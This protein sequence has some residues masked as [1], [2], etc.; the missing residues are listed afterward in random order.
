MSAAPTEVAVH[1]EGARSGWGSSPT[2]RVHRLQGVRGRLQAVERPPGR[3][4]RRRRRDAALRLHG[5]L[6]PSSWRHVRFVE[7][8]PPTAEERELRRRRSARERAARMPRTYRRRRGSGGPAA[9]PATRRWSSLVE[10]PRRRHRDARRRG[11]RAGDRRA[12][13]ALGELDRWAF[14]SD[15]CKHCTN[16]GCLDACPTGA[17]IRTEFQTVI[18]Q[19]DICNGC[20]YC[21]PSC[22]FGVIDRDPYDGRAREVHALLRPPQDGLEPACAKACP[23]DAIQFGPRD[24]LVEQA[25]APRARAARARARRRYLYGAGD[26]PGEQLAGDLGAFFLLTEPP[27]RF[28]LPAQA[29][30]PA[31]EN[32]PTATAAGLAAGTVAAAGRGGELRGHPPP[33]APVSHRTGRRPRRSSAAA[34]ARASSRRGA[35]S[36]PAVGTRGSPPAG[37]G[38]SRA[39]RGVARPAWGDARWSYLYGREGAAR[40]GSD[41]PADG[42]VA[43]AARRMRG[44]R[45]VPVPALGPFI[46]PPVWTWEVPVYFWFGGMATG[47]SFA[48]LPRDVAGD[49]RAA[50]LARK[51]LAG[52][53]AAVRAAARCS[54]SGGRCASCTCCGSSSRARR[55]RWARG[56]STAFSNGSVAPWPP[57]SSGAR[58]LA[59]AAGAATGVIGTYLGSYTGVLLAATAVPVWARSRAF[60]PA[61]FICTAAATG[62]A[63]NRLALAATG[64]P[65][66]RPDAPGARRRS[67]RSPWAASSSCR[68]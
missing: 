9:A 48:A 50:A 40:Y 62:A 2:R 59:R 29:E 68:A 8:G 21:I 35:T 37:G 3:R 63:A 66:G 67:R 46:N 1:R 31:Q 45:E 42:E 6:S 25:A 17:L 60:L 65:A 27:E 53:R 54:T 24:E 55:C 7:I 26:E 57:T 18:V 34:S 44:G 56:A 61:I 5:S 49:H 43:A 15:V 28:G 13:R 64:R 11:R 23:T 30:S 14:F 36:R 47:S 51:V 33:E 41:R 20:G 16:A 52:G 38:R 32:G 39:L 10:G 12:R 4:V 19:P 22:P 58:A